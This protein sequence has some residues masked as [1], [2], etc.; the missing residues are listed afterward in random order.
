MV[1]G[2]DCWV[3]CVDAAVEAWG[4][5][6]GDVGEDVLYGCGPGLGRWCDRGVVS[7]GLEL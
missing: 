6:C 4:V 1:V 2:C 3:D 5:G 7:R